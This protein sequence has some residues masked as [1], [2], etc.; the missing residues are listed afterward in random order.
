MR[1]GAAGRAVPPRPAARTV[2]RVFG[3]LAA[4]EG[5]VYLPQRRWLIR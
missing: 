2:L 1:T 3:A 4:P 5:V